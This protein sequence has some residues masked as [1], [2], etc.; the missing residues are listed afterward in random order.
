MLFDLDPELMDQ[1]IFG[2]ENQDHE[3][4]LDATDRRV[5]PRGEIPHTNRTH[6]LPEWSS[7]NGYQLM[8][9]FVASLQNQPVKDVLRGILSSGHR[10]F[11]RFKDALHE[12]QTAERLF[13]AFK[14]REMGKTILAWYNDLRE[15]DGLEPLAS[16][17][18]LDQTVDLLRSDVSVVVHGAGE[19]PFPLEQVHRTA[20][21]E[22]SAILAPLQEDRVRAVLEA[23]A[24]DGSPIGMALLLVDEATV[25]VRGLTVLPE[26][27]GMGIGTLLVE[28]AL[29]WAES[30]G[31]GPVEVPVP[32]ANERFQRSMERRGFQ[33]VLV[34]MRF[35]PD[36]RALDG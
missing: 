12:H 36:S 3:Y 10:V 19:I 5:A 23:R 18:L 28:E 8:E 25:A 27:R 11:R 29:F 32:V 33:P 34:W 1:I 17:D 6:E 35:D 31:L 24:A 21:S 20:L 14:Q 15:L 26:F 2:M 16:E 13:F 30:K 7:A 4:I 9:R 22:Y